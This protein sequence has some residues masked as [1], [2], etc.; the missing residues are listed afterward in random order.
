MM[1]TLA[2]PMKKVPRLVTR[3]DVVSVVFTL[4]KIRITPSW[5]TWP[6]FSTAWK[7]LMT[8]IPPRASVSRPVTSARIRPRS[9]KA[10]RSRW[11]AFVE[12]KPK[13][14]SGTSAS[15]VMTASMR[16]RNTKATTAVTVPPTSWT[17]PVPTRFRTPSTSSMMRETSS[18]DFVLSKMRTGS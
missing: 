1:S 16:T 8:R 3:L 12:T 18:P 14:A 15:P 13:P 17:R 11:N 6:S 2:E 10:G 7:P 5:K 4:S 9:R